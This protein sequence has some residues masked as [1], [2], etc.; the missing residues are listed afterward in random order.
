MCFHCIYQCMS[1]SSQCCWPLRAF[2]CY[3]F[4]SSFLTNCFCIVLLQNLVILVSYC[5]LKR[6]FVLEVITHT[7]WIYFEPPIHFLCSLFLEGS[8]EENPLV[9][10]P[11][12][13]TRCNHHSIFWQDYQ[14]WSTEIVDIC[15]PLGFL[16]IGLPLGFLLA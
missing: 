3:F 9:Y 12:D 13:P 16:L 10:P 4:L 7:N 15:L 2:Y 14:V 5:N 1:A 8:R 6:I 11:S